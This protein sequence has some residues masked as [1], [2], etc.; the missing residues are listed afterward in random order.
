MT[1]LKKHFAVFVLLGCALLV[2]LD[3]WTKYLAS[4]FLAPYHTH[5]LI[6]R[7]LELSY[8]EN[9][10]AALGIFAGNSFVLVWMTGLILLTMAVLLV[11]KVFP[12]P[13]VMCCFGLIL[14]GG[15]GNLIDRVTKGYVVDFIYVKVIHFPVFNLADCFVVIGTGLLCC[16]FVFHRRAEIE[17][18]QPAN[19]GEMLLNEEKTNV[20]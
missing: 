7:V 13:F 20:S 11:L 2:V 3:Q 10:G 12:E 9:T 17:H 19:D 16:Y 15:V 18:A 8:V 4:E 5:T 6:P 1:L 14:A